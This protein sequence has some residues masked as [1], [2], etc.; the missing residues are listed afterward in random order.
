M[1]MEDT[2][3]A[4]LISST[5]VFGSDVIHLEEIS[6]LEKESTPTALSP[7]FLKKFCQHPVE[8]RVSS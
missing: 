5:L 8:H 6:I 2:P 4:D 1:S 3:V 7:L